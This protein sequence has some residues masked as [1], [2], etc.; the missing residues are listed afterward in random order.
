MSDVFVLSF[1]ALFERIC[2][3]EKVK[4][5]SISLNGLFIESTTYA[6]YT[7]YVVAT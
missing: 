1:P 3:L 2:E 7:I 6:T 5:V 4:M